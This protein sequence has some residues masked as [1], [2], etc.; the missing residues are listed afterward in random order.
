[1]KTEEQMVYQKLK[2]SVGQEIE[3]SEQL[4][5]E[6]L[7]LYGLKLYQKLLTK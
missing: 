3:P 2:S 1:M 7:K 4:F 6:A 5:D